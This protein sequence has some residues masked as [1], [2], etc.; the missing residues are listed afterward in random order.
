[1]KAPH[2]FLIIGRL[3]VIENLNFL[4]SI[5]ADVQR[6]HVLIMDEVDGIARNEDS[7]GVAV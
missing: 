6:H 2:I 7:G 5:F 3:N 4:S 1:M